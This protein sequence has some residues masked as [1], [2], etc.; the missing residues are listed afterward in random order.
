MPNE[1]VATLRKVTDVFIQLQ[2]TKVLPGSLLEHVYAGSATITGDWVNCDMLNDTDAP[3][4]R[5]A[6]LDGVGDRC[7]EALANRS[8]QR[9]TSNATQRV[10]W[11]QR[12]WGNQPP[13]MAGAT[14]GLGLPLRQQ[15]RWAA[16]GD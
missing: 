1:H 7:R 13:K 4:I 3:L 2:P 9:P 16:R 15:Q 6:D 10:I 14:R 5:V 8:Q 12:S 11:E